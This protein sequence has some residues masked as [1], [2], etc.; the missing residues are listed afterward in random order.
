[1]ECVYWRLFNFT[2]GNGT[3]HITHVPL[4]GWKR[5][6][7]NNYNYLPGYIHPCGKDILFAAAFIPLIKFQVCVKWTAFKLAIQRRKRHGRRGK[8]RESSPWCDS[9]AIT[10]PEDE[11]C[12]TGTQS[13]GKWLP[14]ATCLMWWRDSTGRNDYKWWRVE[15]HRLGVPV[16]W[17]KRERR[18][19]PRP[20]RRQTWR[21]EGCGDGCYVCHYL[22]LVLTCL[23]P[24]T[25]PA[26]APVIVIW[27][28]LIH[29]P[30]WVT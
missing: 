13:R 3:R 24:H 22:R 23:F 9:R 17:F 8:R 2:P 16:S 29:V 6:R 4:S 26:A 27:T 7:S 25:A 30:L 11:R 19:P 1:M 14:V 12:R 20:S 21:G 15:S 5:E 28:K 18:G 10:R